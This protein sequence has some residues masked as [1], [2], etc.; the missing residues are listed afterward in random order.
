[1]L[2]CRRRRRVRLWARRDI[3]FRREWCRDPPQ[4]ITGVIIFPINV[5]GRFFEREKTILYAL[6]EERITA[7]P[8]DISDAFTAR[9]FQDRD[10]R[11]IGPTAH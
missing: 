10:R 4:G 5:F 8:R 6:V 7:R 1:M 3:E 11:E 9:R 2:E